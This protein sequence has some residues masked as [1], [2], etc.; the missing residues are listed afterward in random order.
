MLS[1][2]TVF[3]ALTLYIGFTLQALRISIQT[4]SYEGVWVSQF[5][6]IFPFLVITL[7]YGE[8]WKTAFWACLTIYLF[9]TAFMYRDQ[10]LA[11]IDLHVFILNLIIVLYLIVV[12]LDDNKVLNLRSLEYILIYSSCVLFLPFMG[13]LLGDWRF[14]CKF[15]LYVCYLLF[16]VFAGVYLFPV[17]LFEDFMRESGSIL[18]QFFSGLILSGAIFYISAQFIYIFYLL[19]IPGKNQSVKERLEDIREHARELVLKTS[20]KPPVRWQ[21]LFYLMLSVFLLWNFSARLIEP[22]IIL[23]IIF[24]LE[25]FQVTSQHTHQ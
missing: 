18:E 4:K 11:Q 14:A 21:Y 25:S 3:Q 13:R 16:V 2:L 9:L 12:L 24:L 7:L 10:L 20:L 22:W 15:T 17:M 19:P 1:S 6:S 5:F 8:D 23:S